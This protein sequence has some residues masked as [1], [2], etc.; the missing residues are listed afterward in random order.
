MD[1][2]KIQPMVQF[3]L[4]EGQEALWIAQQMNPD[5][6]AYNI[7]LVYWLGETTDLKGLENSFQEILKKHSLLTARIQ[8]DQGR[9]VHIL[10]EDEPVFFTIVD[11]NDES[12][13]RLI[14]RIRKESKEPFDLENESLLRVKIYKRTNNR[15]VLLMLVH[16]LIFDGASVAVLLEDLLTYYYIRKGLYIP[17]PASSVSC[18]SE[19]VEWQQNMLNG[20]EGKR[21][22]KFW[23]EQDLH[24]PDSKILP[25]G[26]LSRGHNHSE[27]AL[28]AVKINQLLAQKVRE[29][30]RSKGQTSFALLL[31][32]YYILLYRYS[33]QAFITIGIPMIGRPGMKFERTIGCFI[34]MVA[35]RCDLSENLTLMIIVTI[36]YILSRKH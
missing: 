1:T 29:L 8:I 26:L 3:P 30:T 21:L 15:Y 34:N 16:H 6:H 22:A 31:S 9:P 12:D 35:L 28:Y 36:H 11:A 17:E 20:Q 27:G 2:I 19:F 5:T 14:D 7:P 10:K 32:V 24:Q 33:G 4:S 23:N 18:F 25:A 13:V